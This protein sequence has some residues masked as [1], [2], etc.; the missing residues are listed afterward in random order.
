MT[1]DKE[2]IE[3]LKKKILILDGAMGTMIQ[4][5]NLNQR[6][7]R[8]KKFAKNKI[9]LMGNN[10]ILNITNKEIIYKI[11]TSYLESGADILETNTFNSTIISQKDYSCEN[12]SYELNYEGGAIA[13]KA[14]DDYLKKNP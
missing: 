1:K 11:H 12:Y 3:L 7:F 8:G 6:D 10:D 14:V 2:L 5:E 9:N 13:R 4:R